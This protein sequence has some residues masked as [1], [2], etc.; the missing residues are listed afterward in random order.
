MTSPKIGIDFSQQGK[1]LV[2]AFA[3]TALPRQL[4]RHMDVADFGTPVQMIDSYSQ[5]ESAKIVV[6]P[7]GNWEYSAYQTDNKLVIEIKNPDE[8]AKRLATLEKPVYKGDKLSL[9]F[10]NIEVRAV[11][12]V[13][14]EF[15]GKNIIT[16]DT[17]TGNLTLRLKDVPWDQVLDLILQSKGLDK[18][19]N[20]AVMWIAPREEIS[21]H[22]KA[23]F[24]SRQELEGLE[25]LRSKVYQLNYAKADQLQKLLSDKNQPMLSKRGSVVAQAENNYLFLQDIPERLAEIDKI[26]ARLDS[27]ARQVMI[28]ARIVAA[29]DQFSRTLGARLGLASQ[30]VAGNNVFNTL[31]GFN[32][33]GTGSTT[34]STS[35]SSGSTSSGSSSIPGA[36]VSTAVSS[37]ATQQSSNV[38]LPSVGSSGGDLGIS[39]FNSAV[40]GLI[41]LEI[42]ALESDG[43]GKL[44]SSPRVVARD[45]A[46]ARILQGTKIP[47]LNYSSSSGA[48]TT[49][50][51]ATL[52]LDVTPRITPD[53]RIFMDLDITKNA[54]TTFNGSTAVDEKEIHTSVLVGNGDTAELGGI[55]ES[56]EDNSTTKVPLLG[57]LPVIGNLFK[58][59]TKDK[60]RTELLIFITPKILPADPLIK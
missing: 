36:S 20:G 14:A 12:E 43:S 44:I 37:F 4:E 39:I 28:E 52:E 8:A 49:F 6:Q 29:N 16:S 57:D 60:S 25:P 58:S 31:T 40:G 15:T 10:Q 19:E 9:N 21:A 5:G 42:Q 7:K 47:F 17:V 54:P 18:R 51:D 34:G 35:S 32:L 48:N 50:I 33:A 23:E 46:K 38:N 1:D 22:E 13:I 59:N 30:R 53:G 55:F 24:Q 41:S 26:I 11:L 27:P 3:K 45:Q 2:L 56:S